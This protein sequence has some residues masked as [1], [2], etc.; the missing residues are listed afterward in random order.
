[1]A[2]S[3]LG[4]AGRNLGVGQP[5]RDDPALD[6]GRICRRGTACLSDQSSSLGDKRWAGS[7]TCP[8]APLDSSSLQL[9]TSK[10][11]H[12]ITTLALITLS[13]AVHGLPQVFG[14]GGTGICLAPIFTGTPPYTYVS[15]AIT[16]AMGL[17]APCS[18]PYLLSQRRPLRRLL[19]LACSLQTLVRT[20]PYIMHTRSPPDIYS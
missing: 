15:L 3:G 8:S 5:G 13:S 9:S 20:R 17:S 1:M 10:I 11:M 16:S 18:Q 7:S 4:W 6:G 12:S 14:G 19:S 2:A